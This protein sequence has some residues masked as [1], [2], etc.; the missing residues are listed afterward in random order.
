MAS[1][2]MCATRLLVT[3]MVICKIGGFGA[4]INIYVQT[5]LM[6]YICTNFFALVIFFCACQNSI[7]TF[8]CF[9]MITLHFLLVVLNS[10]SNLKKLGKLFL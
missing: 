9:T 5:S 7:K 1:L 8:F 10:I 6:M 3:S 2:S 4:R